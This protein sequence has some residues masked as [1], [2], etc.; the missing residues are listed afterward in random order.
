MSDVTFTLLR[1]NCLLVDE[2]DGDVHITLNRPEALNALNHEMVLGI[3]D[4]LIDVRDRDD[5]VRIIFKGAGDRA[6]CAGGDIKSVYHAGLKNPK[7][8]WQYFAD[9]YRMNAIMH[10]YPK[11]IISHIHGY[12]M[13]GGVGIAGNGS[14]IMMGDNVKFA[15]PETSIGFFPDVGMGWTL[16]RAGGMG[17]Y[18]ALT[19]DVFGGEVMQNCLGQGVGDSKKEIEN[20]F[21]NSNIKYIFKLLS[22]SGSAWAEATLKTLQS[23]CPISLHVTHRHISM[24][25]HE[26]Y[27]ESI[28]RDYQLACAFFSQPDVYEGI[29]AAVID[30][31]KKPK[32]SHDSIFNVSVTDVDYYFNFDHH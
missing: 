31:D 4:I 19:G 3:I 1:M 25:K 17:M 32:W 27:D 28:A 8:A 26:T 10:H 20:I 14:D 7:T 5:V 6:F 13:G 15:M 18:V 21:N 24:C 9:E 29:R 12:V 2:K 23:R 30:K 11:P 22:E 16:S